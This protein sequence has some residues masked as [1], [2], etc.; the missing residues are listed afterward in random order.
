MLAQGAVIKATQLTENFGWQ[1]YLATHR[2]V[3]PL[4][5]L[6][7]NDRLEIMDAQPPTLPCTLIALVQPE[8]SSNA[9]H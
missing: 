2:G 7:E 1:D 3:V 9:G 4:F 6:K 8:N 5:A